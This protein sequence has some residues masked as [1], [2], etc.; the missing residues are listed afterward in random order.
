MPI[1]NL[2]NYW[3]S[4]IFTPDGL[5]R[6]QYRAFMSLLKNDKKA[7]ELMAHLEDIFYRQAAVDL[8]QV[9]GKY[10]DLSR[11]VSDIIGDLEI[12]SGN[13]MEALRPYFKKLDTY[14]RYLL[15][16]GSPD[17]SPP[18]TLPLA[19][20]AATDLALSGGKASNLSKIYQGLEFPIPKGFV[21]TTRAF[22]AFLDDNG[23]RHKIDRLLSGLDMTSPNAVHQTADSIADLVEK[24]I[25]P[26]YI[27]E[28]INDQIKSIWP[29]NEKAM[30]LAVRSSAVGEDSTLSFAGQYR[31]VLDCKV[32]DILSA[33]KTVAASKY[34]HQALF[35]RINCGLS[36]METQMAVLVIEM[37]DAM[38]SGV[39]YTADPLEPGSNRIVI[40][41]VKGAGEALVDGRAVSEKNY[42]PKESIQSVPGIKNYTVNVPDRK[43]TKGLLNDEDADFIAR[44]AFALEQFFQT[45]QDVEWCLDKNGQFFLLQ[46]R[47]LQ[48][49]TIEASRPLD[50]RFESIANPVLVSGGDIAC[51]GI[52]SGPVFHAGTRAVVSEIPQGCVLV[53]AN[54]SP[55]LVRVLDRVVAVVTLRGSSAGHFASVAREFGIPVLVNIP[56]VFE[57]LPP[58]TIV[59]VDTHNK[60]IYEGRVPEMLESPC[61][62]IRPIAD[63]PFMRRM[64]YVMSFVSPLSLTDPEAD[65]FNPGGCRSLHDIIR[66]SHETALKKMFHLSDKRWLKTGGTQKL[67]ISIPMKFNVLDVGGGVVD[68]AKKQKTIGLV[69]IASIPMAAVLKGLQHPDIQWG[70]FSHFNWAEHDRIV[71]SG[72][73]ISPDNAMFNSYAVLA[74]NYANMNLKFGYHFVL[75]DAVCGP[76]VDEGQIRF[77]FSGGGA[78]VDQRLLRADFLVKILTGLE[79]DVHKKMDLVDAVFVSPD[80]EETLFHLDMLGR[81]LGATR[82]MDMYLKTQDQVEPFAEDFFKGR[83]HFA[84]DE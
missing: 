81:L 71:M 20:K 30:T 78:D 19:S 18:W 31:S 84:G 57:A 49:A 42:I 11:A 61:A 27:L 3:T 53:A 75:V 8:T 15:D 1:R 63:S 66:F 28:E 73:I 23:L 35:Y 29:E 41:S 46:S 32:E 45:P 24:A 58:S 40:H 70:E 17:I 44:C 12:I 76:G 25:M 65:N 7:H 38:V 56:D 9:T 51:H 82:L 54:A 59:T 64:S 21:V 39:V 34:S 2:F 80:T 33:Y 10:N 83:Y 68:D 55:D 26:S 5:A 22:N 14:A 16:A 74:G 48:T 43:G 37:V 62:K 69:D 36:D 60:T 67:E 6:N 13:G 79:F 47:P 50:C 72:G 77:R 4:K 52:G